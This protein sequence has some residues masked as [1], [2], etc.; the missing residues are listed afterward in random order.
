MDTRVVKVKKI[1]TLRIFHHRA[2]FQLCVAEAPLLRRPSV[3]AGEQHDVAGRSEGQAEVIRWFD[4]NGT[5][6]HCD[7]S[8]GKRGGGRRPSDP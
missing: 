8:A 2:I 5:R 6:R 3:E 7:W 1:E 4:N